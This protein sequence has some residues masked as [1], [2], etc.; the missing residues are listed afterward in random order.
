MP[1]KVV[2][3]VEAT[4]SAEIKDAGGKSLFGVTN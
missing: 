4:W 3:D 1:S 2:K